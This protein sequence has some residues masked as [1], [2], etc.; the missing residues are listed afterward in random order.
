MRSTA[1]PAAIALSLS[2]AVCA[3]APT[4]D[5]PRNIIVFVAD[6]CGAN[7]HRA[8]ELWRGEP[9]LYRGGAWAEHSVATFALR[10]PARPDRDRPPLAQDPALVYRPDAAW[11]T[12]P[13]DREAGGYAIRFEG[14]AYLLSTAPDS[15]NTASA[16]FT[17]VP[18]FVGALDVDGAGNPVPSIAEAASARG[19]S[20]GIVTSVPISHAT[21]AAAGGAHVPSREMYAEIAH[22]LLTSG[23]CDVIAGAGHP[24]YDDGAL[25]R[26]EPI[27]SFISGEDWKSLRA[28]TLAPEGER[29]WTLVEDAG[30]VASLGAGD[31]PLPLLIVA[32]VAQ[33]LQQQRPPRDEAGAAAPGEH[34]FNE[35]VP[36]LRDLSLAA[37][38][39]VDDDPDGFFLMVEGGAVDWAMHDNQLGRTIEEMQDFH[40]AIEAV[41]A[42]L[43]SGDQACDWSNTLV[44]VTADHDHLLWG[45]DS[46]TVAFQPL[47]D[48]GPG[49]LPGHC[50][51][52]NSHSNQPVPL[53][54]RGPGADRFAAIPTSPDSHTAPDGRTFERPPYFHQ[55]EIGKLLHRLIGERAP[56][57][58]QSEH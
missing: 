46:E 3:G 16:I 23:V 15:A 45:A 50:W 9:A 42:R 30:H 27:Y 38:N 54:V 44:V 17:G 57:S 6:G 47:G 53:F 22:Q 58:T 41:C 25:K 43:D 10:K 39:A 26:T 55:S 4:A 37:L 20:V 14:Y 52:F 48:R 13:T 1:R 36:T 12:A 34:P 31:A 8:F 56:M 18:T 2:A 32:R 51:L 29:P 5:P 19:M 49:K 35:G 40:D 7:T 11:S 33:T 28:G 24:E 21:P